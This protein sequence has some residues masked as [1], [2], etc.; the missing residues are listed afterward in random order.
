MTSPFSYAEANALPSFPWVTINFVF[1]ITRF[2]ATDEVTRDTCVEATDGGDTAGEG[3]NLSAFASEVLSLNKIP[4]QARAKMA[5][6]VLRC[7]RNS[8]EKTSGTATHSS[9]DGLKLVAQY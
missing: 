2:N 9:N 6:V 4:R 7:M 5:D 8:F 3:K 1:L